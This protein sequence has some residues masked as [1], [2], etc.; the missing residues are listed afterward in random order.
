MWIAG[1]GSAILIKLSSSIDD[2]IWL[3]PFLTSNSSY[4]ARLQNTTTYI[5]VCLIQTVVAM[6]IA[7]SGNKTVKLLTGGREDVW[8]TER[9][10]TVGA[11]ALL[12]CYSVK[13]SHEYF[14]GEEESEEGNGEYGQVAT[15]EAGAS[16][17]EMGQV[18]PPV[19]T[20]SKPLS[21]RPASS[22]EIEHAVDLGKG[23]PP[24]ED[25]QLKK[26]AEENQTLFVIA[27][28]GSIDDLTLFVPMLVG[29]SFDLAQLMLGAFIASSAI[30]SMCLFLSLCKPIS[31]C[32]S[33][34]P[35]AL[36]VVVFATILLVKGYLME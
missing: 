34:I 15:T 16:E 8:S 10:L 19:R 7:Y 4:A 33:K 5:T 18:Q 21:N 28:I 26:D 22:R 36:I 32:L 20:G 23:A 27:F 24:I 17:C 29:K 25:K 30:V 31:D 35:L 12:A 11:G 1:L 13:L 3:A 2:V 14:Y 9:I 6:I